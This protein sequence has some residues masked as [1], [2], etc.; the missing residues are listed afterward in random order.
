M[1]T[2]LTLLAGLALLPG[3]ALLS[4]L[5]LLSGLALL[6]ALS[7]LALLLVLTL[8]VGLLALPVL[9]GPARSC[10]RR[11]SESTPR[12][13]SRARASV[14]SPFSP[15]APP[16]PSAD[17]ASASLRRRSIRFEP[18]SASISAPAPGSASRPSNSRE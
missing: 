8:A 4:L 3:L 11:P 10:M 16:L 2:G 18:M 13:S 6:A 1:L 12:T 9:S 15:A 17:A 14:S 5:A 7:R